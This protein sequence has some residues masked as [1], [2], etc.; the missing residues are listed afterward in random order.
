MPARPHLG[1]RVHI[2]ALGQHI[3]V[4][5]ESHQVIDIA[6]NAARYARVLNLHGRLAPVMQGGPV[7]LRTSLTAGESL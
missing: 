5:D 4:G 1:C 6:L 2:E 7:H 3:G